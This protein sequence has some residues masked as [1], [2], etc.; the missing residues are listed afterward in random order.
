MLFNKTNVDANG[1]P[2]IC[3]PETGRPIKFQS[4]AVWIY[5]GVVSDNYNN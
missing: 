5:V 2:T 1:K 4:I 3:D